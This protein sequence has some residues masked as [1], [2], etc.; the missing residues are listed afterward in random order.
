M[1]PVLEVIHDRTSVEHAGCC[2]NDARAC[3]HNNALSSFCT[4]DTS[5]PWAC[6][7]VLTIVL[8]QRLAQCGSQVV[9]MAGVDCS[10]FLNHSIKPNRYWFDSTG[11]E[12]II[13]CNHHFLGTTNSKHWTDEFSIS[14]QCSSHNILQLLVGFFTGRLVITSSTVRRF[15]H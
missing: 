15:N 9:R 14:L 2:K 7:R 1:R 11:A 5:E 10:C 3:I 4:F 6:E 8:L 12:Q 13:D